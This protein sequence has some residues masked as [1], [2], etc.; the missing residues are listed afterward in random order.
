M[1]DSANDR[2]VVRLDRDRCSGHARCASEEPDFFLLDEDGYSDLD[3][4]VVVKPDQIDAFRRGVAACPEDALTLEVA[5]ET[6]E[7]P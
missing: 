7:L 1:T 3:A 5:H 2:L 4:D 6:K